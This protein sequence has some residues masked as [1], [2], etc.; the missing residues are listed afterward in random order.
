MKVKI[1]LK[2]PALRLFLVNCHRA[3]FYEN[4][5]SYDFFVYLE[6]DIRVTPTTISTYV[7]ETARIERILGKKE[8]ENYNVGIVRYENNFPTEAEINDKNRMMM[9]NVTRVYWEHTRKP[10]IPKALVTLNHKKLRN[11]YVQM[12]NKHQGMFIAS[13]SLLKAWKERKGCEFDKVTSRPSNKRNQPILGTQRVWI[14]SFMLYHERY[15][16]VQQII[17]INRF[18]Q[19]TVHHLPNKNYKRVGL[20]GRI[21]A[22]KGA[23]GVQFGFGNESYVPDV[24]LPTAIK[25]HLDIRVSYPVVRKNGYVYNGLMMVNEVDYSESFRNRN[26]HQRRV[27]QAMNDF[28]AYVQNGGV[29]SASDIK[30]WD[31]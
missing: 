11:E 23:P 21:G 26:E 5:E 29:M 27:D 19:L 24:D 18:G 17:P 9:L 30:N 15:C 20:R 6:D 16:N 13:R 25:S 28:E 7:E 14:S 2:S 3:L 4:L 12:T 31:W 10:F 1:I 22:V 8:A